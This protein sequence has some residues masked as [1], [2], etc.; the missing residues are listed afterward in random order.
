MLYN[1]YVEIIPNTINFHLSEFI[2]ERFC[3]NN[4][5]NILDAKKTILY[6]TV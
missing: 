5:E 2:L 6:L 4:S 3:L 1:F